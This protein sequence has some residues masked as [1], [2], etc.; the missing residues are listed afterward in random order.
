MPHRRVRIVTAAAVLSAAAA[1][2][3]LVAYL[4]APPATRV[5]PGDAAPDLELP[6]LGPAGAVPTRLSPMWREPMLL[7]FY[8]PGTA[9]SD[10]QMPALER[11]HRRYLLRGLR[12]IGVSVHAGTAAAQ[13]YAQELALTFVI[14]RDPAGEAVRDAYGAR[15]F[16]QA[17][18]I[19]VGGRVNAVFT[20]PTDWGSEE[21]RKQIESVLPGAAGGQLRSPSPSPASPPAT[22][23]A[24]PTR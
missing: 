22:P 6:S 13:G 19:E 17:Y 5:K 8:I 16:P 10:A 23:S 18:L 2:L 4:S 11:I 20:G 14:L 24:S 21:V 1:L 3:L 9:E 7:V 15:D 12:V